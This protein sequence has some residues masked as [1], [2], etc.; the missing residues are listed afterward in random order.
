[1]LQPPGGGSGGVIGKAGGQLCRKL[2]CMS[3]RS[4]AL[5]CGLALALGASAW[6]S[7]TQTS[8]VQDVAVSV[9]PG[10]LGADGSLWHFGVSFDSR[11]PRL[12]DELMDSVVLVGDG[13][14][15]KPLAW[16]GGKAGG[17]QRAG[18]LKFIPIRP[19]PAELELRFAR[20]GEPRARVFHFSFRGW[21]A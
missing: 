1:M 21:D 17:R 8:V 16:E 13:H 12:E 3:K 19:R 9:T 2:L 11:G 14:R 4:F 5:A 7:S 15:I 18:V 20:P 10:H 6:P